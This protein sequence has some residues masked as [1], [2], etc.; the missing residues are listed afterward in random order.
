M[1]IGRYNTLRIVGKNA[2]GLSLSDGNSEVLLPFGEVP[3]NVQV[4]DNLEVFVYAS[5]SGD[6][7]A[8]AQDAFAEV[9]DF[10][11]LTAVDSG[12]NGA[13]LD[14]GIGKDVYVPV[15]EQK[16][17]MHKGEGYV[18]YLHLD[19]DRRLMAS[20]RLDRFI[21]EEDFDFE[22]GDEVSLLISEKT[23]LGYNAIIN[24]RYIGLLYHNELFAHLLPGDQRKGWIKKIRI[25]NKID[26]SLQPMGYGHILETKDVILKALRE[27]GGKIPLGDKSSP[28]DIYERFQISKSAFKKAI[29]GLYKERNI[30]IGDEEIRIIFPD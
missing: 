4:G 28:E 23:D 17:P 14:L 24:N 5:K 26:L 30:S 11:Y 1:E 16:R 8:T 19:G 18:V 12:E 29:G 20:S 10:A 15:R 9:G 3:K 27:A 7:M 22:E 25:G 13:F 2:D 6:L 21:E